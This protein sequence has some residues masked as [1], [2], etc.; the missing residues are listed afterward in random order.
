MNAAHV[1]F[2]MLARVKKEHSPH[3]PKYVKKNE[4]EPE[5]YWKNKATRTKKLQ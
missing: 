1:S 4:K 5:R 3:D 2:T